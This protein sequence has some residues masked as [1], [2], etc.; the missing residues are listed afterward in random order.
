MD[1]VLKI[2]IRT[3]RRYYSKIFNKKTSYVVRKRYKGGEYL[4]NCLDI[5]INSTFTNV[6]EDQVQHLRRVLAAFMYP[7]ELKKNGS[8][9][10]RDLVEATRRVIENFTYRV[11][12]QLLRFSGVDLLL[13]LFIEQH[14]DSA[15]SKKDSI[16]D[17]ID[18]YRLAGQ[19]LK[20]RYLD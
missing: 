16:S 7:K 2:M 6:D 20:L 11:L 10:E 14:L 4:F 12:E 19:Y 17:R 5:F 18:D 9:Y 3:M 8:L 15:I 13:C 1:I